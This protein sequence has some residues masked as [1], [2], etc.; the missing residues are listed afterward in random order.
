MRPGATFGLLL[1]LLFFAL[2]RINADEA[3]ASR[4]LRLSG[5]PEMTSLVARWSAAFEKS[6]RNTRV[7]THLTGSDT[8]MAALYTGQADLAL[9]GRSPTLSEIQAFEWIHHYKPA[10]VEIMTGSLDHAGKS[11]ALVLF[12]HRD[13]P[14]AMLTLEQLDAI[15]GTEHRLAPADLLIWG[16][17]GLT[18]EWA[19]KPIHLYA[20]DTMSGTGR[21]F[22]HV[23]LND[24]RM[25]NWAQLTEFNDTAVPRGRTHD[26]G[27]QI[28]AALAQ[29]RYGL[30][31]ASL[32]FTTA[33]VRPVPLTVTA[34]RG[35]V[36]AR[37]YP[38]TRAV[39]ACYGRKPGV[40]VD[41]LVREF[42]RYILSREGQQ[43]VTDDNGYLPLTAALAAEQSAKLE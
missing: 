27:R 30:A 1:A 25:M 32:D 22:R 43:A 4:V 2:V 21:F 9:L 42:L 8:G 33:Q 37:Q 12:V 40:P 5:N 7:E 31:V 35:T 15:F 26:A 34:T 41:P 13:N 29:D 23:V 3:T 36:I 11:P 10:Q 38:L 19:D 18:G 6:H 39:M 16:Q 28:I 24:R 14:L 20:P 17:L